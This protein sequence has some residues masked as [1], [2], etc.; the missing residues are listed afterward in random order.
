MNFHNEMRTT[1]HERRSGYLAMAMP[2]T[3][4]AIG[5]TII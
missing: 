2:G 5:W 3:C 4:A 1:L